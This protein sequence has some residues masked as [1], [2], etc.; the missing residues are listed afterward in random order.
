M[1]SC[2]AFA[3]TTRDGSRCFKISSDFFG[4]DFF[5]VACP[6][7][8]HLC[9]YRDRVPAQTSADPPGD[10]VAPT[11]RVAAKPR[12]E[13]PPETLV[14]FHNRDADA[15]GEVY[16]RYHRAVWSVAVSIAHSDHL[17]QEAMQETFIRAWQGAATFDP[18]RPL[19]PWLMTI[20]RHACLDLVRRE[21]RPTRGGHE[22]EQDV[23]VEDPG[24]DQVW[25]AWE[26]QEAVRRLTDDEREIIQLAFFDDLTQ[27]Q[28]AER[29]GVP[30][31]TVKSRS[32]RAH[33]RL[34]EFLAH[35]RDKPANSMNRSGSGAR[36]EHGQSSE[37]SDR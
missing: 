28:I 29:L 26:V 32:H 6:L 15:L 21:L 35:L 36:T 20:A 1:P 8:G 10:P 17:A 37:G 24:M 25:T 14:R 13:L 19:G 4:D 30:V 7:L 12:A 9:R 3:A 16:E 5:A 22:A 33:R 31:G 18:E 2:Q 23:V 11:G 34:A 27:P